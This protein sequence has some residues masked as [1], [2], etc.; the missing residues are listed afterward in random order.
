MNKE[1]TL[2]E[3]IKNI[4]K[5]ILALQEKKKK[6]QDQCDHCTVKTTYEWD[7][8]DCWGKMTRKR[9]DTCI[10]CQKVIRI[11]II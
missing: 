4:D 8:H 1:K 7:G 11:S 10:K 2:F 9:T 3:K 6:L 5:N